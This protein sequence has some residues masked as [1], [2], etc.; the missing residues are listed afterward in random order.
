MPGEGIG[1]DAF[2]VVYK[3]LVYSAF[4]WIQIYHGVVIGQME[5]AWMGAGNDWAFVAHTD[6]LLGTK[7][8]PGIGNSKRLQAC[9][10]LEKLIVFIWN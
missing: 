9:N 2:G 4:H 7:L 3:E 8:L 10:C 6:Y 1:L 5:L